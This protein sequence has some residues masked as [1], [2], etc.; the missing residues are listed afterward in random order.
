[1]C[2]VSF[3]LFACL[4]F[5]P[6]PLFIFLPLSWVL[7]FY[8]LWKAFII[9]LTSNLI[10][11]FLKDQH[12][13]LILPFGFRFRISTNG[14]T[15]FKNGLFPFNFIVTDL[16]LVVFPSPKTQNNLKCAPVISQ[17]KSPISIPILPSKQPQNS[18]Q[19]TLISHLPKNL[20]SLSIPPNVTPNATPTHAQ[21]KI[22]GVNNNLNL[23]GVTKGQ[24]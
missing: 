10:S 5:G 6:S 20:E 1:V 13:L 11:T 22:K 12:H 9:F 24:P 7:S 23:E 16:I 3:E 19:L 18:H 21:A 17:V 14:Y 8:K 15:A 2:R 4:D